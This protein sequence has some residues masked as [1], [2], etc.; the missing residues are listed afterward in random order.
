MREALQEAAIA[1]VLGEVPVG[2][3][4]VK[5]SEIIAR[6][7][8][9]TE[10]SRD[11]TAHAEMLAIRGAARAV[12]AWRLEGTTLYVTLEP[13]PMCAGAI[14]EARIPLV[15]FGACDPRAGAA[16]SVMD[17]LGTVALNH[18]PEVI[19]GVLGEECGEILKRFFRE[20]RQTE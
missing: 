12:G 9:L 10:T 18:R 16:G 11:P 7:H 4:V 15:V 19:Q 5:G 13:C 14:V 3:V 2:A 1:L 20:R 17:V 6:A 8:N